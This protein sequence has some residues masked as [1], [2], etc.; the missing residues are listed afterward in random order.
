MSELSVD[1]F[2]EPRNPRQA[3]PLAPAPAG[4]VL[5]KR[6]QAVVAMGRRAAALPDLSVL[7]QDAAHLVAEMLETDYGAVAEWPPGADSITLRL[8]KRIGDSRGPVQTFRLP[9]EAGGSLAG[10]ALNA[11]QPV[12]VDLLD[13]EK[14]FQD[15]VL[16]RLHIRS[17]LSVPLA[18]HEQAFGVLAAYSVTQRTFEPESVVFAESVAHL[19]TTALARKQTED[20][21]ASSRR[22]GNVILDTIDALV[23]VLDPAGRIQSINRAG[24][25]SS[26]FTSEDLRGR[27]IWSVFCVPEE[28]RGLQVVLNRLESELG[29]LEY[30]SFLVTKHSQKRRIAWTCGAVRDDLGQLEAM[31]ATGIDVTERFPDGSRVETAEEPSIGGKDVEGLEADQKADAAPVLPKPTGM[32][33]RNQP[34]KAYPYQQLIAPMIDRKLPDRGQYIPVTCHDISPGGFS[35]VALAP[36][37]SNEYVVALGRGGALTYLIA[38]VAHMTRFEQDGERRYLIGCNYVGRADY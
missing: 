30:K 17:A 11:R 19:L 23:V 22:S 21:L 1:H 14:R 28:S 9:A 13:Q 16:Q 3:P 32:E 35:F 24:Q 25:K 5:L 8:V 38:Q 29:P 18:L 26:G 4:A 10:F 7:T 33:R 15:P 34:R 2:S 36:P 20:A 37:E 31:I 12:L 27:P 6:Q